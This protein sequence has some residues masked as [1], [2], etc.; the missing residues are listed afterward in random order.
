MKKNSIN[1]FTLTN[2]QVFWI[3]LSVIIAVV[4]HF[5]RLPGWFP[6][7]LILTVTMRW[8][9]ATKRLKP[10]PGFFIAFITIFIFLA[11]L[12]FQGFA[13]NRE[14]S[15]TVLTT[16]TVLKLLETWRKRDAWMIVTLCYFVILTRFFY[17]QDMVLV[18]YLL[19]S[20]IVIT[21]TL[22]VLQ[23]S[24][25][26][27]FLQKR[28]I[29]QTLGLLVTGI[30]L[31]TLFFLFFPRLGSPI[32][33]S[34]DLFGEGV[35]GISEDMSPGSIS[36]LFD[37]DSTAF[38]VIFE[39]EIPENPQMYWRGP[40]M[41]D[42][43]GFTWTRKK[44]QPLSQK[45]D[46]FTDTGVTYTYEVEL[47]PTGQNYLFALDYPANIP[48]KSNL[49]SDSQLMTEDKINQL[50]HYTVQSILK[51]YNP[52]EYLSNDS[53]QRLLAL[54]AG[55][56]P[57]TNELVQSWKTENLTPEET[58]NKALNM[59]R[60]EEFYYSY[61]PPLLQGN[62]V[63]QFLFETRSGFCEHYASAF[64]IMMRSAG[65]PARIVTGYQGG[66]LNN[67]YVLVKQSDAHAWS[68]VWVKGKGWLRVDPTAAVSPLRVE[69]GSQAIISEKGRSWFDTEW[70]RKMGERYDGL[71]H[72]WN[73]W[74]RDYDVVK[75][76]ALF[77]VFGFDS[78]DGKSIAVILGSIML[79]TTLIVILFL[80]ITQPKRR[81]MAYDKEYNRFLKIFNKQGLTKQE[82]QGV[83][84]FSQLLSDEK[85]H[86][87]LLIQ[88]FTQL[89]IQLRFGQNVEDRQSLDK[90]LLAMI[91]DISNQ[92]KPK[93]Q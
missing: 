45:P 51:E 81:L 26:T 85:P 33:G 61:S 71:R 13:L 93:S 10:L 55:Y 41:W 44:K 89:Y 22:F 69:Y 38:R 91:G 15:V 29:K 43:D 19:S 17:S 77:E 50:R 83:V 27:Q 39:G 3:L 68:E 34:P 72:K 57:R 53:L 36:Q 62:T 2:K 32:W 46:S 40:V 20:V 56:N 7:L 87:K 70:S 79:V 11:I 59:F 67:D 54:P 64:T 16:M 9:T 48:Q 86:L 8:M 5:S 49:L 90:K 30:P 4:P 23:H 80:I 12:Y 25:S 84:E 74:I 21:H 66:I 47:E 63:D 60:N 37:D 82:G 75:Q 31:A 35:T 78:Q 24:N 92:M 52:Y 76:K 28:E 73:Q 42:F 18:I 6:L 1:I 88:D 14:I 65:I 58:V